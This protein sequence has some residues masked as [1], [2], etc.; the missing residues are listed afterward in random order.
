MLAFLKSSNFFCSIS[1]CSKS[2]I[3]S[4]AVAIALRSIIHAETSSASRKKC[5]LFC[6]FRNLC[7]FSSERC[8]SNCQS[9]ATDFKR[10]CEK[11]FQYIILTT[12]FLYF[13]DLHCIVLLCHHSFTRA[14]QYCY[15]IIMCCN[16]SFKGLVLLYFS[17]FK[18][19]GV[20]MNYHTI[21]NIYTIYILSRVNNKRLLLTL[22]IIYSI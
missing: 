9:S 13:N 1:T 18:H 21:D 12:H 5:S 19:K 22:D 3:V 10:S 2:L 20:C 14:V 11:T 4:S 17:L 6:V 8:K 16:F 15:R 7:C